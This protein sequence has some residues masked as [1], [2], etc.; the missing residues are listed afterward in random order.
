MIIAQQVSITD[1]ERYLDELAGSLGS[2]DLVFP[3]GLRSRGASGEASFIQLL[4]SWGNR[5]TSNRLLMGG[6]LP[7]HEYAE[8]LSERLPGQV[9]AVLCNSAVR[10]KLEGEYARLVKGFSERKLL[11]N[12]YSRRI[13]RENITGRTINIL[14]ADTAGYGEPRTVYEEDMRGGFQVK[15]VLGFVPI[16]EQAFSILIPDVERRKL[17]VDSHFINASASLLYELF[18][19]THYHARSNF[20]G[21]PLRSSCRGFQLRILEA[22]DGP[23]IDAAGGYEPLVQYINHLPALEQRQRQLLEISVFDAGPGYAQQMTKSPL[24]A[25]SLAQERQSVQYCF[26]KGATTKSHTRYGQGLPQVISLLRERQ[27]FLRL[28]T[29]RL[30]LSRDLSL[31]RGWDRRQ[32]PEFESWVPGGRDALAVVQGACL[33]VLMPLQRL[34]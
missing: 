23:L 20:D 1:V 15:D 32:I 8:R 29:G 17:S 9:A 10:P 27:G 6:N 18:S 16:I 19:N 2:V 14:C 4:G 7:P 26:E 22:A 33:T 34:A 21:T 12:Y 5:S 13:T 31:E 28:R 30:S 3:A 25:I 24:S 11:T